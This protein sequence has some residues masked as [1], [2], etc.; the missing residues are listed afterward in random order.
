VNKGSF[1]VLQSIYPFSTLFLIIGFLK[2]SLIEK[3]K[4]IRQGGDDKE[5]SDRQ[6]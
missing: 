5:L 1:I 2:S 4:K 6:V 3:E